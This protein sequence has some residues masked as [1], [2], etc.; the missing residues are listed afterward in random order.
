M[1]TE[2][3]AFSQS[4]QAAISSTT[5]D[6]AL[7]TELR[8]SMLMTQEPAVV[9]SYA[10]LT[11]DEFQSRNFISYKLLLERTGIRPAIADRTLDTELPASKFTTH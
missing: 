5:A 4:E 9:P 7:D 6:P 11:D 3:I 2:T 1:N 10:T 8:A